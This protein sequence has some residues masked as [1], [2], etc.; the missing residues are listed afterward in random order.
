MGCF[1]TKRIVPTSQSQPWR[2]SM[3]SENKPGGFETP[4]I[5]LNERS[6]SVWFRSIIMGYNLLK[7]LM[8]IFISY[9]IE[10]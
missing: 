5:P 10:L 7:R 4:V 3:G 2:A 6:V 9:V 1:V 8:I